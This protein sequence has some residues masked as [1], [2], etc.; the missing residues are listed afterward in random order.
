MERKMKPAKRGRPTKFTPDRIKTILGALREGNYRDTAAE[1]AGISY[2]TLRNWEKKG[3][4][5]K[6]GKYFEFFESIKRAE[7]EGEL[8]HIRRINRA[9]EEGNWQADAWKLERK[10][11][12]KWGR[13]DATKLELSGEVKTINTEQFQQLQNAIVK[14]LDPTARAKLS[15]RLLKMAGAELN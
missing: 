11:P 9:G 3:A 7:A 10:Y 1:G 15:E 6:K 2:D 12:A 5:E 13:K 14:S 8:L 4:L